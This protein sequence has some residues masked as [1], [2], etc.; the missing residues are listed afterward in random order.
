MFPATAAKPAI[1][2]KLRLVGIRRNGKIEK[3]NTKGK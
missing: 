3:E 1:V 2:E